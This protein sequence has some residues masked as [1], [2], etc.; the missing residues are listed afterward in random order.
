MNHEPAALHVSAA[1]VDLALALTKAWVGDWEQQV[2]IGPYYVDF[3]FDRCFVVEVDG[4]AF[5]DDPEGE[6]KRD[7]YLRSRGIRCIWHFPVAEVFMAPEYCV[8]KIVEK[9][10]RLRLAVGP[11][12]PVTEHFYPRPVMERLTAHWA[13]R[14]LDP[15]S[16]AEKADS[17]KVLSEGPFAA[18]PC[19]DPLYAMAEMIFREASL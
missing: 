13:G 14:H 5:H 4:A 11:K 12:L 17:I 10:R 1:E 18:D 16:E 15:P 9:R 8:Q 6:R 2:Q 3:V 7:D 19:D